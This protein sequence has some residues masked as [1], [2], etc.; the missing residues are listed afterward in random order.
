MSGPMSSVLGGC[1]QA[2]IVC[3]SSWLPDTELNS[4][5]DV[6]CSDI[7]SGN[8]ESPAMESGV[9]LEPAKSSEAD[10][11]CSLTLSCMVQGKD[12]MLSIGVYSQARTIEAYSVSLGGQEE[13]YLGT[14]RGERL[15]TFVKS[16]EDS[17]ITL[18]KTCFKLD[19]PVSSCKLKLLSL[20]GK[21]RVFLSKISV[22]VTSVPERCSQAPPVLGH[23]INMERVQCIMDSMGGKLSP[24]AEQL[25]GMVRAQQKNQAPFGA[26]LFQLLGG[27]DRGVGVSQKEREPHILSSS[28]VPDTKA[29][30]L[31]SQMPINQPFPGPS[32]SSQNKPPPESDMMRSMFSSFLQTQMSGAACNPS[33][34]SLLPMLRNI[35]IEKNQLSPGLKESREETCLASGDEKRNSTLEQ[36]LSVHMTRMERTLLD[37]IDQKMKS[38][39]EHLDARLDLVLNVIQSDTSISQTINVTEKLVNGLPDHNGTQHCSSNGLPSHQS[40]DLPTLS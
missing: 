36:L 30:T 34:D 13:E 18:Y 6:S 17:P 31:Q 35:C 8:E 1:P 26:H 5:L 7:P 15:Y 27:L 32:T 40:S 3:T 23:S 20:G 12:R 29:E 11:P 14:S 28:N 2:P 9:L 24:G 22:Q 37:H 16:E 33:A 10:N 25:M 19:F 4:I 38:L 21:Q 39:Q